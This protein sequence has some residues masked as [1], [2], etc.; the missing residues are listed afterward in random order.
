M[1][2][3]VIVRSRAARVGRVCSVALTVLG[4][5]LAACAGSRA[6]AP[7]AIPLAA[8]ER[9]QQGAPVEIL[10][11]DVAIAIDRSTSTREPTG[12]DLDGDGVV[13]AYE[14]S[15]YTDRGDSLLAAELAA[16]RRLVE[17]ATLEGMRFAIVSYSGQDDF[18]L[19]D[20]VTQRVDRRDARLEAELTDDRSALEAAVA[21]VGDRGNDGSS[22]FAPAMRLALRS[23]S[24][25]D[26]SD[27]PARRR[28]VLFLSD[29]QTPARY[30][31]ME[32]FAYDDARM[33]VEARRAIK[34]GV[35]F[36]SFG[37]GAAADSADI[38]HALA[39][40]AGATGGTYRAVPDPRDLY[41]QMLAALGA[42][43]PGPRF[44]SASPR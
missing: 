23:L 29:S 42:S 14:G 24:A 3:G 11:A 37:I 15:E 34:A 5:G 9:C 20:S 31:P 6:H 44:R 30:A 13:G 18:P 28:R 41:C 1:L 16:V 25:R 38:P 39:Q 40:I 21:R 12:L 19:E 2:H 26:G 33:E 4:S 27:E 7:V 36:H 8:P 35:A 22:S 17:A 32:R 43:D 10:A